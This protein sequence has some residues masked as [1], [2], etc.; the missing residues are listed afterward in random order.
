MERDGMEEGLLQ[1]S[2]NFE[3]LPNTD[4][5]DITPTGAS[6][7][8]TPVVVLSTLVALC[9]SFCTGCAIGYS[10]PADS[11]IL[12][13]LDIS[14]AAYSVFGSSLTIGGVIGGLVS[15][16]IADLFGRKGAM[17]FSEIFSLV[18]WLAIA[19]GKVPVYIAEVTPKNLRGPFASANELLLACGVSL[20]YFVG[21]IITWRTLALIGTTPCL[22]QLMGLFFVPESPRWLAKIGKE[23]ELQASLQC[24]RGKNSD[25]SQEVADIKH[26]TETFEQH[27]K[28]RILD[29]FQHRYS[30]S[31]IVGLGLM[32]LQ[33]FGGPNALGYYAGSIFVDAGFS[34]S[35]GTSSLALVKIPA[36]IVSV[37]LT[38]KSGRRP[39]LIVSAGGM[40][41]SRL[42]LGLAFCFQDLNQLKELTPILALI[43]MLGESVFFTLGMSGLP[44]V[45]MAEIFP[46]NVKGT[47]GSLV[48]ATKWGSSWIVT[49]TFNF[50]MEWSKPGTFFVYAVICS[51]TVLFI[52]KLVPETKGRALEEIQASI[53]HLQ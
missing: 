24:L 7:T 36:G 35:I 13:D 43:G 48:T 41:L 5:G 1:S 16:R 6:A 17:W 15:G 44:W 34:K 46:I 19:F 49:Y 4:G 9:G 14:V 29:L 23:I 2:T 45:I 30:R 40:F 25:I 20:M 28:T 53:T 18:G 33:Q 42:L 22:V 39:L 12:E 32:L 8:A 37:I 50:M 38:D 27:S 47:A 52:A 26:Y 21:N 3:A 11:G 10:S 51:L 31:L